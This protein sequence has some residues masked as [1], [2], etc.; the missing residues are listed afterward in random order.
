MHEWCEEA[1]AM[2]MHGVH[3]RPPSQDLAVDTGLVDV[4]L[5]EGLVRVYAFG[6]QEPEAPTGKPLIQ[7]GHSLRSGA[8]LGSAH[9]RHRGN[10]KAITK[11]HTG[12]SPD[13]AAH[14]GARPPVH[15]RTQVLIN[16]V[17]SNLGEE[18]PLGSPQSRQS[19][20]RLIHFI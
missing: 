8:I 10:N 19:R 6:D 12:Y 16:I 2:L 9:A 17:P 1:L 4:A 15:Q 13:P 14:A 3:H 5:G 11:L 7:A 20:T 18:D